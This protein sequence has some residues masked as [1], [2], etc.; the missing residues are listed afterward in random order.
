M[1]VDCIKGHLCCIAVE[2]GC[3]C[4]SVVVIQP[5]KCIHVFFF[6]LPA[7]T[8]MNFPNITTSV[9]VRRKFIVWMTKWRVDV[10]K[11]MYKKYV[12]F[13]YLYTSAMSI[14]FCILFYCIL[15]CG[16]H[17]FGVANGAHK[18]PSGR[19]HERSEEWNIA[20]ALRERTKSYVTSNNRYRK[21]HTQ[22]YVS[23]IQH[24]YIHAHTVT[25]SWSTKC[26]CVCEQE[27]KS[28]ENKFWP[29][30]FGGY[31]IYC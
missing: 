29:L 26:V 7:T 14:A 19:K 27:R 2:S 25:S 3:T 20:A 28:I 16:I 5:T 21:M 17:I 4:L 10:Q 13:I 12:R 8:W 1:T 18:V 15:L 31:V 22:R 11:Y 23:N 24:T 30:E 9:F 6:C